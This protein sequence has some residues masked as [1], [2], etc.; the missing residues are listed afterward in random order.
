[1]RRVDKRTCALFE[2][3][4]HGSKQP[5]HRASSRPSPPTVR[6]GHTAPRHWAG[7]RR[8]VDA[9]DAKADAFAALEAAGLNPASLQ[10]S[11]GAPAW[12]HPGMSGVLALGNQVVATFGA[13]HPR[14]LKALDVAGPMVACE[15]FLERVPSPKRA[16]ERRARC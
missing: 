2:V 13:L 1:M 5:Q 11:T 16:K 9:M 12:Y 3:G 6:S 15:V 10:T 8:A 14:V 7:T 4:P